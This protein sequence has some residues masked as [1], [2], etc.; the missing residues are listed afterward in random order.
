MFDLIK[1]ELKKNNIQ[2]YINMT[3]IISIIML[4]FFIYSP[5][6]LNLILM[7]EI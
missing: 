4:V 1:I 6:Y 3:L 7:I 5:M 2:K